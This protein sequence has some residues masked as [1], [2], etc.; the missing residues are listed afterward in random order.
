MAGSRSSAVS[1][2]APAAAVPG[3]ILRRAFAPPKARLR[4]VAMIFTAPLPH[5]VI[6]CECSVVILFRASKALNTLTGGRD[7]M[8]FSARCHV[9]GRRSRTRIGR[10][11][12]RLA[13]GT[14]DVFCGVVR[15]EVEHCATA[16]DNHRLRG[17][18]RSACFRL[19]RTCGR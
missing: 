17:R 7:D 16:W 10:A 2:V 12:W 6:D 14:I 3:V 13:E 1:V 8:T 5:D 19:H 11:I 9:L 18:R 4:R 15:G